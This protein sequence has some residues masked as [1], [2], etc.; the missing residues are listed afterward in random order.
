ML[1]H[2][3]QI[4]RSRDLR[5][6]ILLTLGILAFVRIVA[7]IPLPGID[8]A[9]LANFL[10]QSQNQIFNVLSAFTGGSMSNISINLL[11][12][13]PY[14]TASIVVQLL[15]KIVPAWEEISKEGT[16]GRE[17]LNQYSRYLTVPMGIVQGYGTLILLKSQQVIPNVGLKEIAI[18]L[19]VILATS[20]FVMWLGELISERGLGNGISL[21]I[22]LGIVSGLPQQ[23]G[24]TISIAQGGNI[25][26][27]IT[28]G[29]VA[30]LTIAVIVIMNDAERKVPVTYPRRS[31]TPTTGQG[32]AS[33]LPLKVNASGVIPI[34]FALSFMT[35]P[36]IIARFLSTASS[37]MLRRWADAATSFVS[38]NLYYGISYFILVF[39]FTFFY[40][41]VVFQP[42]EISENLQ[43]QG[44][45]I[46][47]VRPGSETAS[48]LNY[49]ITR[50]TVIGA[51]FLSV[52]AVLPNILQA[53]SGLKTLV[54]GGT[55]I[56]I[57]VSVVIETSRQVASQLSMRRYDT[58]T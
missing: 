2:L 37:E 56:L 40:T 39:V 53:T 14:I 49:S 25:S 8:R 21:I 48:F 46:P 44:G 4:W 9:E 12:V 29:V 15:T 33:Y 24:N 36:A 20:L 17:K 54:I 47:G 35:F 52:I 43:K 5:Y 13:G 30:L 11:G 31:V 6:K 16:S 55:S 27:L 18:M 42:K 3:L 1:G 28:V 22:A 38:N 50:L 34:I 45:F 41:F 32:V 23:F 10:G 51:I 57:V 19:T 26:A 7:H 58:I